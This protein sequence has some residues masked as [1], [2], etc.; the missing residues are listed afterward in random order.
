MFNSISLQPAFDCSIQK[1]F[2]KLPTTFQNEERNDEKFVISTFLPYPS[3][4]LVGIGTQVAS[5]HWYFLESV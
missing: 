5:V 2:T 3:R 4:L 1:I